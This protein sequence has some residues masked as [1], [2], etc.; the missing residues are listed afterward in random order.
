[1]IRNGNSVNQERFQ[2]N[3]L[4]QMVQYCENQVECRRVLILEF[5]NEQFNRSHCRKTCDNCRAGLRQEDKDV[6]EVARAI[7]EVVSRKRQ[8]FT[9]AQIIA[10]FRG[11]SSATKHKRGACTVCCAVGVLGA[12]RG[13]T[14]ALHRP[15]SVMA[16]GA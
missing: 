9:L 2:L 14:L 13:L 7:V 15:G 5:F 3:N 11:L 1:M 8:K 16:A 4:N 12:P 10:G 6:T